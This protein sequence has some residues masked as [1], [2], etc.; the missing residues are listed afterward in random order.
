MKKKPPQI[1]VYCL[2]GTAQ[3]TRTIQAKTSTKQTDLVCGTALQRNNKPVGDAAHGEHNGLLGTTGTARAYLRRGAVL[4]QVPGPA[5]VPAGHGFVGAVVPRAVPR[6]RRVGDL[7]LAREETH[8]RSGCCA[9][10]LRTTAGSAQLQIQP[11]ASTTYR[12]RFE[13]DNSATQKPA[14]SR[15]EALPCSNFHFRTSFFMLF[16]YV[17]MKFYFPL[18]RHFH[19]LCYFMMNWNFSQNT[20]I[21]TINC[22]CKLHVPLH[23]LKETSW[24]KYNATQV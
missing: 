14:L 2:L 13:P 21:N 12:A 1:N 8:E 6:A 5:A 9:L 18:I 17:V 19:S 23:T 10:V 7:R 22:K 15:G 16:K 20:N 4:G 24:T 3:I 11:V